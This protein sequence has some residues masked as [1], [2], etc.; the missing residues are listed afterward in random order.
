[1]GVAT[2]KV[3]DSSQAAQ[4]RRH[5]QI[6]RKFRLTNNPTQPPRF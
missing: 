3:K 6:A 5:S 1:M 2:S 4:Y